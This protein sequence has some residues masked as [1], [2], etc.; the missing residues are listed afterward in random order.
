[1]A[2]VASWS[3]NGLTDGTVITTSTAGTGDTA[4]SSV[5]GSGGNATIS[6]TGTRSPRI[7]FPTL[8][9]QSKFLTWNSGVLGAQTAYAVRCYVE[10]SAYGS[11]SS[12]F[13]RFN[14]AGTEIWRVDVA[15]SGGSPPGQIRLR[16]SG[17]TL[18]ASSTTG[19]STATVYR[20]EAVVSS[21]AVTVKVFAGESTSATITLTGTVGT[22][23]D[24]LDI[25]PSGTASVGT[26]YAD[27]I[28]FANT[29]SYIGP[30]SPAGA[31]FTVWNGTTEVTATLDGVWNGTAIVPATFDRII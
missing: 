12:T 26:Q 13:F 21:G 5:N 28:A 4:F 29:A 17:G 31:T 16:G 10:I 2:I 25:G 15:G 22:T 24:T 1:M 14:N 8:S 9:S 7:A 19:L 3:G 27:D 30:V 18:L 6:A 20:I 23:I 11:T